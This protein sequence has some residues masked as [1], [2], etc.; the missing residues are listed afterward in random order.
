[1]SDSV[2]F[3]NLFHFTKSQVDAAFKAAKPRKKVRG[4]TL[5][6]APKA[7]ETGKLLVIISKAV[8]KAHERNLL[9]RR[10]KSIFY[11]E[12]CYKHPFTFI[13]IA[14]KPA[15]EWSFEDLKNFLV[16]ETK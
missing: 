16:S 15:L 3:T 4:F 7:E 9:R 10:L 12:G 6:A 5:L 8:G 1:M 2:N 11:E 13:L 14:Y